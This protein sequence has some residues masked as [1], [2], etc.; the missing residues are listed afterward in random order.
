MLS[1]I[2]KN[3]LSL[4][5]STQPAGI[6]IHIPFC[7]RK[8][9]Y[10]DFYSTIDVSLQSEFLDALTREMQLTR[11]DALRFDTLYIGGGTPSVLDAGSIGRI[12]ESTRSQFHILSN[13]EITVEVNPGTVNPHKLKDYI[14]SGVN[15][16]NI[17]V[18]SFQDANLNFLGRLHTGKS[19]KLAVKQAQNTGF[20]NIGLD[21]VF[22]LPGQTRT[23]WLLD[24]R[25]AV[26]LEP[27]HLSCYILSY[28]PETPMDRDRKAGRFQPLPEQRVSDLFETTLAFLSN[29]GYHQYEISNFA[30]SIPGDS[31][32][33]RSRHNQKYWS[34]VPYIGL[35]P[36]AHSF[37]GKTRYWNHRNT[38]KYIKNLEAGRLAVAE[39]EGL[40]REQL[41]ME[42]IYL[43]LR[44]TQGIFI[45]A[46]NKQFGISF[47]D[48]FEEMTT[49]LEGKGLIR[50]SQNRCALT[51]KGMLLLDSIA[52]MF[53]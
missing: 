39:K 22:G 27:A 32:P 17:G 41:M 34:F 28:E 51:S 24:L 14:D 5:S 40:N 26:E 21:L 2:L 35:G 30:R 1:Y 12:I 15:R 36:S 43:G 10:C 20:N 47:K 16:I 11:N 48:T 53:V 44:Q 23:D 37:F 50:L 52:S 29:H 3:S 19:A 8:C 18:Q 45:D 46:F 25:Q 49:H 31:E 7:I 9:P 6:Y 38:G 13:A 33:F 42:A 4:P